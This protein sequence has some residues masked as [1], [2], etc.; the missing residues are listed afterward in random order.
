M[1]KKA[2]KKPAKKPAKKKAVKPDNSAQIYRLTDN[3]SGQLID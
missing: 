1:K 3:I 2:T